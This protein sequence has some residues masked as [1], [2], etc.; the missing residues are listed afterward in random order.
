[1]C[2]TH[3]I[4]KQH[5]ET[6]LK[7]PRQNMDME[8][9]EYSW[10]LVL[11]ADRERCIHQWWLIGTRSKI[12]RKS[13]KVSWYL[14]QKAQTHRISNQ[15]LPPWE[16]TQTS[17][18]EAYDTPRNEQAHT[19]HT[20]GF[21]PPLHPFFISFISITCWQGLCI[22]NRGTDIDTHQ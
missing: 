16:W 12:I 7:E 1:M 20:G 3:N 10:T 15:M 18:R 17:T 5:D 6:P 2:H 19:L 9:N 21:H 13:C 11:A 8:I 4:M 14:T 22:T